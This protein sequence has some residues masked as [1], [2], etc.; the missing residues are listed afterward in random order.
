MVNLVNLEIEFKR[1]LSHG[2]LGS[3]NDEVLD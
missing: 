3:I 1:S 2:E